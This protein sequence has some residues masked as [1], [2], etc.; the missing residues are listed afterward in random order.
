[1]GHQQKE[2]CR[3]SRART[4]NSRPVNYPGR[5]RCR[6]CD[7]RLRTRR[8]GDGISRYR[9]AQGR[10][11][12][13]SD[14]NQTDRDAKLSRPERQYEG[15]FGASRSC[16]ISQFVSVQSGLFGDLDAN[17]QHDWRQNRYNYVIQLRPGLTS[18]QQCPADAARGALAVVECTS[19]VSA[20]SR[21]CTWT[22]LDGTGACW[23]SD[24]LMVGDERPRRGAGAR[25][26]IKTPA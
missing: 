19:V 17:S 21:R 20:N 22:T 18:T 25:A 9:R 10:E 11:P 23:A 24:A 14:A 1:M 26:K 6:G 16:D 15:A 8:A 4:Q 13:G 7:R 12:W 2:R 3:G 5:A